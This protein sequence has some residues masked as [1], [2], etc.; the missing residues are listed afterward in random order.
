MITVARKCSIHNFFSL[1]SNKDLKGFVYKYNKILISSAITKLTIVMNR[2]AKK[3]I[4]IGEK[5]VLFYENM[6]ASQRQLSG[7]NTPKY[8][9][10]N[11][12]RSAVSSLDSTIDSCIIS[13]DVELNQQE[14]S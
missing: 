3:K 13:L 9:S 5:Y 2:K 12:M 10:S 7:I 8:I 11:A 14:K 6:N 4:K 1:I